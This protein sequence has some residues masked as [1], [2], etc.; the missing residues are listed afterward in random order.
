[1]DRRSSIHS[2]SDK[3]PSRSASSRPESESGFISGIIASRSMDSADEYFAENSTVSATSSLRNSP[4]MISGRGALI[5]GM[6]VPKSDSEEI[7]YVGGDDL[8]S[9]IDAPDSDY[10]SYAPPNIFP[11][12][13]SDKQGSRSKSSNPQKVTNSKMDHTEEPVD[14]T[15]EARFTQLNSFDEKRSRPTLWYVLAFISLL[16]IGAVIAVGV[17]VTDN[18]DSNADKQ[19]L[20]IRQQELSDTVASISDPATLADSNSPQ[21]K[22]HNWLVHDDNLWVDETEVVTREMIVQRYVLAAFYFAT[23]GPSWISNTWLQGHECD[24]GN[25]SWTGINCNTNGQIRALAL[26][27]YFHI[28]MSRNRSTKRAPI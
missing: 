25:A 8:E 15:D 7:E 16:L 10:A 20:T 9:G 27:K 5:S 24:T 3:S 19:S 26:G 11:I 18:K 21:A 28:K 12:P 17:V 14:M 1:M 22:A 23:S 4:Q 2:A 6:I 13:D